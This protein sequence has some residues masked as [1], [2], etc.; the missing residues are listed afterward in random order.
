V[1]RVERAS[2]QI[3]D[4][5]PPMSNPVTP[6]QVGRRLGVV[7]PIECG[8]HGC[9]EPA[10][11]ARSDWLDLVDSLSVPTALDAAELLDAALAHHETAS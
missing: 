9:R 6:H 10:W 7:L 11:I 4:K 5:A 1:T 2:S 3:V 8:N